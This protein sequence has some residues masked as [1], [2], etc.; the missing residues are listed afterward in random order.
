MQQET[1][2]AP[3]ILYGGFLRIYLKRHLLLALH[4]I[5]PSLPVFHT[6]ALRKQFFEEMKLFNAANPAVLREMYKCTGG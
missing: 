3:S 6:R 4:K 1:E 5:E 2:L